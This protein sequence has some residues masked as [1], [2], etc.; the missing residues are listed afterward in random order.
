MQNSVQSQLSS[1]G[2]VDALD[3][4]YPTFD[5]PSVP[6]SMSS[7]FLGT[8]INFKP[9]TINESIESIDISQKSV[10]LSSENML[11]E[12]EDEQDSI[13]CKSN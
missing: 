4:N 5:V 12:E 3:V 2:M 9:K 11:Q 1:C 8:K 6:S 13:Y 7:S 10:E